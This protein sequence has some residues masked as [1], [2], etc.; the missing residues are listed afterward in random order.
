M[1]YN[2][3]RYGGVWCSGS[4]LASD[5]N[6]VGSIPTTPAKKEQVN[7]LVLFYTNRQVWYVITH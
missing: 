1:V 4:T 3:L 5:S 2:Y 6:G 7:G